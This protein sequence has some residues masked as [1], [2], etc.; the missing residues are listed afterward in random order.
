MKRI[1]AATGNAHKLQE[2]RQIL[3]G[4]EILSL[5][6]IKLNIEIIEDGKTFEE[7]ARKKAQAIFGITHIPTL[8]DDSGLE[9]F[10]LGGEPGVY[11][12]R[13]G[14]E[15]LDDSGRVK[16]LLKN[17]ESVCDEARGAR[18]ACVIVYICDKGEIT[19][20]GY[21][22]GVI[23]REPLGGNGFGYDP[24]FYFEQYGK[25][26]AQVSAQEK[27]A[28]SHRGQALREFCEKLKSF[29]E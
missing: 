13:Y 28:V 25:T 4:Y 3:P 11:S 14:G 26:L 9:V 29:E 17:M 8:A 15:G 6:D 22:E 20:K 18:F 23:T 24:V 16:L 10:A 27:N 7:N 21:C 5:D 2:F 1:I 19:A 12:A